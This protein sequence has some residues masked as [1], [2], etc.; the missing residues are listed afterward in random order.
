MKPGAT[1]ARPI[2]AVVIGA[3]A[4][5][6]DALITLADFYHVSVDYLLGRTEIKTPYP[7]K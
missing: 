5:G 2:E 6:V 4:G 3:S 1:H 7:K